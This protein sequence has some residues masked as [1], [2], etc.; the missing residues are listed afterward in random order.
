MGNSARKVFGCLLQLCVC[1][2]T[3]T[4][5][6]SH[7]HTHVHTHTH[8]HTHTQVF[9][10]LLQLNNI[11]LAASEFGH[12]HARLNIMTEAGNDKRKPGGGLGTGLAGEEE[13]CL[14][15]PPIE[16]SLSDGCLKVLLCLCVYAYDMYMCAMFRYGYI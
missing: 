16:L 14:G 15:K 4:H 13:V 2:H 11:H 6:H 10:C 5:S 7:T 12:V 1:T 9:G 8:T 3:H